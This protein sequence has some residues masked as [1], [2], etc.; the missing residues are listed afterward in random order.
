M[1]DESD[2][3]RESL[4]ELASEAR[5][6]QGP[7]AH[8]SP[9]TLTA[10]HAGELTLAAAEDVREHLAVCRHCARLL[11]DLPAFLEAP[12]GDR[13]GRE[14]EPDTSWQAIRERLPGPPEKAGRRIETG[15]ADWGE[16]PG[17]PRQ[18]LPR[19]AVAA[20]FAGVVLIAVPLWIIARHLSSPEL[21][22]AM[23]ELSTPESQRGTSEPPPLPPATVHA[24]AASTTLLLRL[25][26]P[27]PDLR[28][29][30]ELLAGGGAGAA[31]IPAGRAGRALP[32]PAVK[33]VDSRTL[34]L[35]LA[36]RQLSPGRYQL[37]V[38]DAEQPSAEPLGDFQLQVV[39]P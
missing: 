29:H 2:R 36:R 37:R 28:F 23:L 25:A 20:M 11:L 15:R 9:E 14:G 19:L 3:L 24:E 31:G 12:A 8:P 33:I 7:D 21:P 22:P 34:V 35:V 6:R 39:E 17:A 30:V 13:E 1:N 5:R 4:R 18:T 16:A 32:A 38:L 10:Y 26:R 27:Q